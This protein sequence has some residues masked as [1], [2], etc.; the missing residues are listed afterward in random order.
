MTVTTIIYLVIAA[1]V[2]LSVL[3]NLL[4]KEERV[5]DK[6]A[7]AMILVPLALRLLMIK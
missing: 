7:C 3:Y 4:T 5:V 1:I 6:I 2:F